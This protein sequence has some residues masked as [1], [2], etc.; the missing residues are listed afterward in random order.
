MI[1]IATTYSTVE[2]LVKSFKEGE[3]DY[4]IVDM[5]LPVKRKDLFNGSWFEAAA[6]VKEEMSHGVILQGDALKLATALENMISYD[7]VQT[8]YLEDNEEEEVPLNN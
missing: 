6:L 7:N 4:I 1:F 2:L 3:V 5:Y 8:R